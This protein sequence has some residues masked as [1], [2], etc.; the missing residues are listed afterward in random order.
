MRFTQP[1]LD[2]INQLVIVN[3]TVWVIDKKGN[4]IINKTNEVHTMR[5]IFP[6]EIKYFLEVA[7][8]KNVE[9]CPF[10]ELDKQLT[11]KDWNMMVSAC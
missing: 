3:F 6:Q 4:T 11:E 10:L 9:F 1:V 8:F 5:F 7:G 2:V